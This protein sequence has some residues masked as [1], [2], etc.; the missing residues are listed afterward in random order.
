MEVNGIRVL[1]RALDILNFMAENG[2]PSRVSDIA[3]GTG[4]S[5]ATTYRILS[6]LR[7]HNVV[8]QGKNSLYMIGP[9]SLFWSGAYRFRLALSHAFRAHATDLWEMSRETVHLF[10]FERDRV[11]YI[12]KMDSPQ[13]VVMRSR[14]GAWRDLYS[15]GGGRAVLGALPESERQ[16]Y[17]ENTPLVAH[18]PQTQTDK[19]ALLEIL[20]E[21]NRRGYQEENNENELGLRC[22]GAP[23]LDATAYPLGAVSVSAPS[24]R[25]DDVAAK[26]IGLM[27]R[28]TVD[29]ITASLTRK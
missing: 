19:R 16:S 6:T 22:V 20:E 17:L 11:Y 4:L 10:S 9:T 12:D 8:L 15:T 1:E 25:M 7:E 23:V 3:E 27:V 29:K 24:Y 26:R 5:P 13:T 2:E 28:T 14:I 21:G 18:T